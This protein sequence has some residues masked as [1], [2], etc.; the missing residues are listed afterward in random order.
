L[1]R[2]PT[3]TIED[4]P[5]AARPLLLD[6]LQ[7]SPTGKP[8]NLHA[9]M[10]H[11]PAVLDAYVSLRRTTA[12]A[13]TL[14]QQVRTAL[15]LTAAVVAGS[16]Y[17]QAILGALAGRSGWE[18]GQVDALLAGKDLGEAKTDALIGVIREAAADSGRVSDAT[19]ARAVSAGWS[20]SELAEA[21]AYL[22]LALFTAYFLNY[23]ATEPDL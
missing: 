13:G 6:L 21:F 17:A 15:M 2:I 3:H 10:A 23:A 5:Q 11:A 18:P 9:Q 8:L 1:T 7:L 20:D 16:E 19:W 22:G 12:T 14:D 4:A